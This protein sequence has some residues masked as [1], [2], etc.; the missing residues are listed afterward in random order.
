MLRLSLGLLALVVAG[1]ANPSAS[2]PSA[3]PAQSIEDVLAAHTDSLMA[4]EGVTGV[5]QGLCEERAC[6][7]VYVLART[8]EVEQRL[9]AE[10]DGYPVELV[11]TGQ[12]RPLPAGR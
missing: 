3:V 7:R 10:I 9:P 2:P 8:P 4:V 5:G 1:C 11:E 12:I 6:I